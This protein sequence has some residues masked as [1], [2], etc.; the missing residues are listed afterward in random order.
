MLLEKIKNLCNRRN[1]SR[2]GLADWDAADEQQ[3][4]CLIKEAERTIT[5]THHKDW[6]HFLDIDEGVHATTYTIYPNDGEYGTDPITSA[7]TTFGR[8]IKEALQRAW[9]LWSIPPFLIMN[10]DYY[11]KDI[12]ITDVL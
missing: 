4:I 8:N 2:F 3:L 1:Q 12:S 7:P 10:A 11:C 6:T 9:H 5:L